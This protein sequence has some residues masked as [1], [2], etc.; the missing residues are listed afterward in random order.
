MWSAGCV[1]IEMAAGKPP[2]HEAMGQGIMPLLLAIAESPDPP[3][4][5]E[6]FPEEG[7]AMLQRCFER[8]PAARA[9]AA[10]LCQHPF[11]SIEYTDMV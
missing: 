11:L 5:P 6:G 9:R 2:W 10:E 4:A 8:V 7:K 3:S 1:V